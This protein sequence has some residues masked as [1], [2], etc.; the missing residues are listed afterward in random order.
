MPTVYQNP[1]VRSKALLTVIGTAALLSCVTG[2]S[3][4]ATDAAGHGERSEGR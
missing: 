1:I 2:C 3:E 4:M